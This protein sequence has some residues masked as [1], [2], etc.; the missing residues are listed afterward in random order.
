MQLYGCP[1][2]G[3]PVCCQ[4]CCDEEREERRFAYLDLPT[5]TMDDGRLRWSD[6]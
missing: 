4:E 3:A 1:V 6:D 5:A 2:C